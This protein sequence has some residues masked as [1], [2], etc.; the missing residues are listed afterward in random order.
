MLETA[1]RCLV[2]PPKP[3][4]HIH[5]RTSVSHLLHPH[6]PLRRWLSF[7]GQT[8]PT[9]RLADGLLHCTWRLAMSDG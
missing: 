2:M 9:P 7:I 3:H 4:S 5:A 8:T 6:S 1:T